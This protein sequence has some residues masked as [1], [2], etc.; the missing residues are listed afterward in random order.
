MRL[1]QLAYLLELKRTKSM[2]IAGSNLHISQQ[3]ISM[4]IRQLEDELETKLLVRTPKGVF[5]TKDG[6]KTV[7]AGKDIFD[8]ID[9]LKSELSCREGCMQENITILVHS[10]MLMT[11]VPQIMNKIYDVFK[12]FQVSIFQV[13]LH[14]MLEKLSNGDNILGLVYAMEDDI[15]K[16]KENGLS[17]TKIE[18]YHFGVM[19][20]KKSF[21]AVQEEVS[22]KECIDKYPIMI[23][24]EITSENNTA[25]KLLN[26]YGLSESANYIAV[27]KNILESLLQK[28]KAIMISFQ[29]GNNHVMDVNSMEC[30]FIPL[31]EADVIHSVYV[32]NSEKISK[33]ILSDFKAILRE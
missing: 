23:Y 31:K 27:Q 1:E 17:Y 16:I 3:A 8:R 32:Y 4:A 28:D 13:Q 11:L 9:L 30:R 25:K 2:N 20:N 29:N 21:L 15:K 18:S 22:L 12:G 19:V 5:L 6:E 33:D 26:K 7:D 14:T 24:E 10:G